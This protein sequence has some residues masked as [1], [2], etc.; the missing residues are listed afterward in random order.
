MHSLGRVLSTIFQGSNKE[1]EEGR[2]YW[3]Q[4]RSEVAIVRQIYNASFAPLIESLKD[5]KGLEVIVREPILGYQNNYSLAFRTGDVPTSPPSEMM[6]VI[7]PDEKVSFRDYSKAEVTAHGDLTETI[8]V[9]TPEELHGV[10][11]EFLTRTTDGAFSLKPLE[12]N[13]V[14]PVFRAPEGP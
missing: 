8:C 4:Q 9:A 6:V 10:I 14:R 11:N 3:E 5:H 13:V 1:K 2:I 7:T 12:S